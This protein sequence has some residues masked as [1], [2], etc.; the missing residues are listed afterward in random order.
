MP[1]FSVRDARQV[2]ADIIGLPHHQSSKRPHMSLHDRAAQFAPFAA[3]SGYDEMV[4][5]EA[6]LTER[7]VTPGESDLDSLD[8][9]FRRL[10]DLFSHKQRPVVSAL[11]FMP[12]PCKAGGRY[13]TVTGRAKKLDLY[14]KKLIL[15][16]AGSPAEEISLHMDRILDLS[17]NLPEDS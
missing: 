8:R 12:D 10:A 5:E 13:E 6:R 17:G 2:Y 11:V 9:K 15:L 14:E 7:Q 16:G 4:G 3:L 1:D